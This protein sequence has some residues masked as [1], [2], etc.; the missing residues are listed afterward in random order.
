L[1]KLRLKKQRLSEDLLKAENSEK[2]RLYGELITANLHLIKT[3]DKEARVTNYYDGS[4]ITIPLDVRY[5]PSKNA[6]MYF[7][8]YSKSKTAIV[9][10]KKQLKETDDDITYIESVAGFIDNARTTDEIDQLRTELTDAGFLR[11]R[12]TKGLQ[13]KQKSKPYEYFTASGMRILAGRNNRENDELTLK[14]AGRMDIW[15]HTKDIPGS[16]TILFT[17]GKKPD[18]ADLFEAAKIAAWHSKARGS[19]NVPV[20]ITEVRHVKKPSGA[21]PGMVIFTDNRTVYVTPED[22]EKCVK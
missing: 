22:P 8:K 9:E 20:D 7:K 2:Y 13:K 19:E 15:L 21:K 11:R 18:E 17:E 1:K 4:P 6:Q 16:H 14:K 10:K 3:G 12:K 5:A